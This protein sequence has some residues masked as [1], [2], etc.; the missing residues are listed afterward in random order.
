MLT[1]EALAD[2]LRGESV[3]D[4]SRLSGVSAKTI[5]RLRQGAPHMPN[6]GTV[7]KLLEA[8]KTLKKLANAKA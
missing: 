8:T 4:V 1:K 5:Y 7:L 6:L 2:M 3:K